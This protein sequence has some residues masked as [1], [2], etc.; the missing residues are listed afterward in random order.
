MDLGEYARWC[1]ISPQGEEISI[2]NLTTLL[3]HLSLS[4]GGG[5]GVRVFGSH[6]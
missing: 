1:F 4:M 5:L 6:A 3:N 2:L